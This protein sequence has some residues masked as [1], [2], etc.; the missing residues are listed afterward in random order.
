MT[1]MRQF[2][3]M[4]GWIRLSIIYFVS[5]IGGYLASSIF[6]PYMVSLILKTV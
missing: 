3:K 4:I 6:V 5:G 2:E 1:I